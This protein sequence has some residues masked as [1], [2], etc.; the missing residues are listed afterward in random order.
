MSIVQRCILQWLPLHQGSLRDQWG[1]EN[2][3]E[4]CYSLL[5]SHTTQWPASYF[6]LSLT[7]FP[8]LQHL[9]VT[10]PSAAHKS[11][12][13]AIM[14][15]LHFV[16]LSLPVSSSILIYQISANWPIEGPLIYTIPDLT[17]MEITEGGIEDRPLC[18]MES[19][20]SQ[21]DK[22]VMDKL[23]NY[24]YDHPDV[25]WLVRSSWS[26]QYHTTALAWMALL[27]PICGH[28][29]WWCRPNGRE[30]LA[31]KTLCQ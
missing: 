28:Q 19:A 20:F 11:V 6:N 5:L 1:S 2:M 26:K 14:R 22:A 27:F 30:I 24:V 10:S 8:G 31:L 12:L 13:S 29:N 15:H 21:S 25:W 16:L 4:V 23:Q 3:E 18:F 17:M 9:M 7:F